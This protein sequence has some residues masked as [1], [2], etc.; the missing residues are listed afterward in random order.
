MIFGKIDKKLGKWMNNGSCQAL[1][2]NRS[3]GPGT[4]QQFR[5]CINGTHEKCVISDMKRQIDC[6]LPDCVKSFGE[7]KNE[8]E[9]QVVGESRICASGLQRQVRSCQDGKSNKCTQ[10]ESFRLF[11][12]RQNETEIICEGKYPY[13]VNCIPLMN[14]F[15]I[16]EFN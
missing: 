5:Q 13:V 4:Q 6:Q 16:D 12:C 7:W 10:Q 15:A 2:V 14:H 8:G 1:D 11:P 9:C 3:C